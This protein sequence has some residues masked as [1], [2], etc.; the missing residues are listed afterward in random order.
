[1]FS[2][3]APALSA[4]GQSQKYSFCSFFTLLIRGGPYGGI[5]NTA[6]S[7]SSTATIELEPRTAG[8][9]DLVVVVMGI[10]EPLQETAPPPELVKLV[11]RPQRRIAIEALGLDRSPVRRFVPVQVKALAVTDDLAN[12]GS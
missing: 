8:H 2:N 11:E 5:R 3:R 7:L 12:D 9:Q 4:R 6:S 10:V 1:M